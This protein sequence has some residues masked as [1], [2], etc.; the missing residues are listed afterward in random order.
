MKNKKSH[1]EAG[2]RA[3]ERPNLLQCIDVKRFLVAGL[4][5]GFGMKAQAATPIMEYRFNETGTT[6]KSSCPNYS[7]TLRNASLAA[8]DLHSADG[9]GVSGLSGDRAFDNTASSRMGKG[10]GSQNAGDI[11]NQSDLDAIDKLASFT[12]QG[13]FKTVP[14][15]TIGE[16]ARLFDNH[17]D[18]VSPQGGFE[19]YG[20]RNV[21]GP[22]DP[23]KLSLLVNGG[24]ASTTTASYQEQNTWVF[25]AVSYDATLTTNNVKFYKGTKT[26]PVIL[27][28][29]LSLNKGTVNDEP[30]GLGLGNRDRRPSI[31][32]Q[33]QER[34]FDGFLDNMRIFGA[35][36]GNGGV[37]SLSE[38]EALRAR[39]VSNLP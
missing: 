23:G 29:T 18:Q 8:T 6:A 26:S 1:F 15:K 25:F 22:V 7:V 30:T 10:D 28:D 36:T 37:L 13:W 4:I 21:N 33:V 38:L 20:G 2:W 17:N 31:P 9:A 35:P 12:L 11:A 5:F 19:L 14:G 24:Q 34:P 32:T 16:F 27:I 39:D 3:F